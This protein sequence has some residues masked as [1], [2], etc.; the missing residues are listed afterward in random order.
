MSFKQTDMINLSNYEEY[1]IL[2]MDNEL[3]A[4]QK[5]MVEAFVAQ[6]PHLADELDI[7]M[8]TKLPLDDISFT[9]KEELL[10][11]SMKVNTVDESLLLYIDN[12]LPA[13][14]RK[15]VE[16][17][18]ASNKDYA[19]QHSLLMQTKA[20]ATEKIPYPHKK[21]LYRHTEKV[22]VFSPWM[23]IAA[24]VVVLLFGSLYYLADKEVAP[25]TPT[26]A[27]TTPVKQTPTVKETSSPAEQLVEKNNPVTERS[28]ARST[29]AAPKNSKPAVSP[30]VTTPGKNDATVQEDVAY[31]PQE[32]KVTEFDVKRFT[33]TPDVTDVAINKTI[34]Y[35]PVTSY[36]PER[37]T[38]EDPTEP[39][40]TDGDFKNTKKTSAKGLFR[41]VSRFI[42]RN[43]GIGTANADDQVL[44]GAVSI[45]L[46]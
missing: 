20:D 39:A 5:L 41:K 1:F 15:A 30:E 11:P 40:V 3:D 45:K 18:I 12:E 33:T 42:E 32:R 4:E 26:T 43:T 38:D 28:I 14:E 34:A 31:G 37:K 27:A 7:L 35:N 36:T 21:E 16:Q 24:A 13:A 29:E 9:G 22:V 17:Q 25:P 8:S 46:K 2:Y 6:H 10:S 23:R 19:L 44:I